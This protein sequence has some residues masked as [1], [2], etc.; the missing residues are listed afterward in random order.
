MTI[1]HG[2]NTYAEPGATCTD[3]V[4][5]ALLVDIAG[6]VDTTNPGTYTITYSCADSAGNNATS[7]S[8]TVTV[9]AALDIIKPV[10][11][12]VGTTPVNLTIGD[13][14]S[15]AGATCTDDTDGSL[16]VTDDHTLVDT[17]TAGNYTITYECTDSSGNNA[18]VI[19]RTITVASAPAPQQEDALPDESYVP[20]PA[21]VA[22]VQSY[23]AETAHGAEHVDRWYRTLAAFGSIAPMT[24]QEAQS[25]AE[26][27]SPSRWN[28]IV[29]EL[30]GI[31]SGVITEADPALVATVQSYAAE[32]AHGAEHVDRWYRTLAAFGSIAPM[33]AQEA[34]SMAET[35][36]PSRWNPIVAALTSMESAD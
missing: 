32:T 19:T 31:E 34:Q 5:G 35:Y 13:A 25:M 4:D 15:D 17:Q 1:P 23:A 29:A 27:Y 22:T 11:T 10:I 12:L 33:T 3:D 28:P 20:D 26:T 7:A 9:E 21:L 24:A 30:Q 16:S 18:T 2:N 8:R 6:V 36:S 14:Y